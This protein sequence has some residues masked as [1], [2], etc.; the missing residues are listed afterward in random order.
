M[1]KQMIGDN[2]SGSLPQTTVEEREDWMNV[3]WDMP[4]EKDKAQKLLGPR[5]KYTCPHC[6]AEREIYQ[7]YLENLIKQKGHTG[8]LLMCTECD[9]VVVGFQAIEEK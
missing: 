6:Q 4:Y 1:I 9:S 2:D 3:S 7:G 5:K 8:I